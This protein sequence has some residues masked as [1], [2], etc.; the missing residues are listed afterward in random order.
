MR[1][2]ELSFMSTVILPRQPVERT[3][4]QGVRD[5]GD[6]ACWEEEVETFMGRT[7]SVR[8][9]QVGIGGRGRRWNMHPIEHRQ[10]VARYS[11]LIA[12]TICA[13]FAF[14]SLHAKSPTPN[15]SV[16]LAE[17]YRQMA[18]VARRAA[19]DDQ[20]VDYFRKRDAMALRGRLVR[21]QWPDPDRLDPS[22][23]R[24]ARFARKE[25]VA[26]L[27]GGAAQRKPLLAAIAQ[28]NFDCWLVPLP[29]RLGVPDSDECRRRFYFAF[30]GLE[31]DS[32]P[33]S[34]P[35]VRVVQLPSL[36]AAAA[37]GQA[38][39]RPPADIV[40]LS[41][42]CGP[43]CVPLAF[44]GPAADNLIQVLRGRADDGGRSAAV[45]RVAGTSGSGSNTGSG[46][47]VGGASGSGTGSGASG[48]GSGASGGGTGNGNGASGGGT[49]GVGGT[50]SGASGGTG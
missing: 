42:N 28:V 24:E 37:D 9:C 2:A 13:V 34:N 14:S 20:V 4:R 18:A 23:L 35:P 21:P 50:G 16:Y 41:E 36:P 33:P 3:R 19:A 15:F 8:S 10:S 27:D 32:Q 1:A 29:R 12:A 44:T 25:L 43:N 47:T 46:S 45:G 6:V 17:G 11:G 39:A 49:G 5:E 31:P 38:P 7:G 26:R 40:G 48:G 30:A 22:I